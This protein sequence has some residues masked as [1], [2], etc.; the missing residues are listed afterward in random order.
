MIEAIL[1]DLGGTLIK[2]ASPH[3]ILEKIL[4]AHG[5]QSQPERIFKAYEESSL[6]IKPEEYLL[7]YEDFW[8]LFNGRILRKIGV[9][10]DGRLAD[11]ITTEW[12]DN[13]D[14]S[15][16]PDV[17]ETL[18]EIRKLGLKTGIVTNGYSDDITEVL[19]RTYLD[20]QFEVLIGADSVGARK[21]SPAIFLYA[22]DK[23]RV[24]P[25]NVLFVGD[26]LKM[27]YN[28]AEKAGLKPLLIDREGLVRA[29]VRKVSSLREILNHI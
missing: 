26:D 1:F 6:E 11:A 24:Y 4:A 23:L 14:L 29:S 9:Q 16:Y 20:G 13:A 7:P 5:I 22:T 10:D 28:G 8:R 2:T 18:K 21:P 3:I 12:W 19:R 25:S 17:R 27:D 15:L